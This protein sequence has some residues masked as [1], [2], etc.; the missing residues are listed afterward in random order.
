MSTP[1]QNEFFAEILQNKTRVS[2]FLKNGIRL[3]GHIVNV[4]QNT[5]YLDNQ[6]VYKHAIATIFPH[7]E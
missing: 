4:D 6:L 2:I 5:L 7:E 3:N 1:G